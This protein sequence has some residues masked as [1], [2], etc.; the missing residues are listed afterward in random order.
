[1]KRKYSN[2]AQQR[3]IREYENKL[4]TNLGYNKLKNLNE[5]IDEI[6]KAYN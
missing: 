1:M 4:S 6:E 5:T 3:D 2:K